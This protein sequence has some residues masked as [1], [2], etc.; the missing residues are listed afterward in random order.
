MKEKRMTL[1][2]SWSHQI[3]A[4]LFNVTIMLIHLAFILLFGV[5][6]FWERTTNDSDKWRRPS[7]QAWHWAFVAV[8]Y[9][10]R[11]SSRS[12][13]SSSG[14]FCSS[15][16]DCMSC[17]MAKTRL[18][19]YIV[20]DCR[21]VCRCVGVCRCVCVS[22]SAGVCVCVCR[23]LPVCFSVCRCCLA[24]G[25]NWQIAPGSNV[26]INKDNTPFVI[27]SLSDPA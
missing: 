6:E 5:D 27:H 14:A 2:Q 19:S 16:V 1:W 22:V 10:S 13:S 23:C 9:R 21:C 7:H 17:V 15:I 25:N 18:S 11:S 20:G 24:Y 4:L 26:D 3:S 12:S 8:R